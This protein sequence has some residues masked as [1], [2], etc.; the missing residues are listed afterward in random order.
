MNGLLEVWPDQR[1]ETKFVVHFLR[2]ADSGS[3]SLA[4]DEVFAGVLADLAAGALNDGPPA[5]VL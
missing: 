1:S 5:S 2:R 4:F 3:A